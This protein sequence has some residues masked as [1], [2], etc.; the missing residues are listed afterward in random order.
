[1]KQMQHFVL[2]P[3]VAG[4][5]CQLF[6]K[7]FKKTDGN[8]AKGDVSIISKKVIHIESVSVVISK[9]QSHDMS[10]GGRRRTMLGETPLRCSGTVYPRQNTTGKR[11][12]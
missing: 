12:P 4:V 3:R 7:L 10:T 9:L 8:I 5:G 11:C 1:M 6:F 2:L